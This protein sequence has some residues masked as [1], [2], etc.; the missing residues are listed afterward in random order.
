M[1][2]AFDE[3]EKKREEEVLDLPPYI[4]FV[5]YKNAFKACTYIYIYIKVL[6]A[7]SI[8]QFYSEFMIIIFLPCS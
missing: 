2:A 4:M 7:E 8:C 1:K 3:A 6:N 5:F